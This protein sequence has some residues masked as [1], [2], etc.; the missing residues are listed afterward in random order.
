[1]VTPSPAA[2]HEAIIQQSWSRCREMGLASSSPSLFPALPNLD[3]EAW[4][5]QH[6][7]L[8][9]TTHEHVL[10]YYEHVL[11]GSQALIMLA[12]AQGRLLKTWGHPRF[13]NA[14]HAAG[15]EPGADWSEA[16]AGTNPIGTALACGQAV[17]VEHEEHFLAANRFLSGSAAPILDAQRRVIAVLAVSSD[18]YLPPSHTLGTVKMMSQ[19]LENRL[20][21][22]A[23]GERFHKLVF[24]SGASNL[25]SP[26]A[27]LLLF[28]G[29][30]RVIAANRRADSLLGCDPV[31]A[32]LDSLFQASLARILEYEAGPFPLMASGRSRLHCSL[33]KAPADPPP[34]RLKASPRQDPTLARLLQQGVRLLEK[35]IPLLIS[36][37]TGTGKEVLAKALHQASSRAQ[38]AFVALNC[39]AIPLELVEAELFGY[40]R[41]A[42]TGANQKGNPGLIRKADRGVL[43]LDEIGDMPLTT[44]ARLLRVL[45]ER[46]IQPLGSGD[47]AA[48]DIRVICATHQDLREQVRAGAFREDL[49]Y[50][51]S[52]MTLRLPP[53]R[54]RT[55][56]RELIDHFWNAHREPGQ[57]AGFTRD[58]L[59]LLMRQPWPGNVRQ[60][61][62]VVRVALVL[63]EE[64]A[65]GI[66]HLP[67]ELLEDLV[68]EAQGPY[69]LAALMRATDGNISQMA[70]RLGVSRNTVYKR[71]RERGVL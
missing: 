70:K 4:L 29:Q 25:D 27:G 64:S 16:G 46:C 43:F 24:N 11:S 21:Q 56:I 8:L 12:D 41:G 32:Q 36:G 2:S 40:E 18:S 67:P 34:P 63:A 66:E 62:S 71:L 23:Y 3:V 54:E 48:V 45:Q 6:Q 37:E 68:S 60:L 26:W 49:Y 53:L 65:I 14:G 44:Q 28:D 9:R 52:G 17:H 1:M 22:D 20:I 30:G 55:D 57:Q 19:T 47:P 58:A 69:D 31:G 33:H 5:R 39:A 13:S 10:P 50:R 38:Q 61:A 42:F 15:F 59:A 35:D 7:P 51:L